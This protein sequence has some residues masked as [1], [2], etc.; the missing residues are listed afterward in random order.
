MFTYCHAD[1]HRKFWRD[2]IADQTAD[3][4]C[5]EANARTFEPITLG[6]GLQDCALAKRESAVLLR[7]SESSVTEA[8]VLRCDG[9]A[10]LIPAHAAIDRRISAAARAAMALSSE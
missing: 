9:G 4:R 1:V 8:E 6:K 2:C 5:G 10:R 3:S 7:V